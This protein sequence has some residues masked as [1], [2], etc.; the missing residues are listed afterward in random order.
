MRAS[1]GLYPALGRFF[2]TKKEL[3]D[4]GCMSRQRLD[5][6]LNGLKDFT[7][8]EKRALVANIMA[9]MYVNEIPQDKEI[10]LI[11]LYLAYNGQFDTL[12]RVKE[13][14]SA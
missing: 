11:D 2:E 1:C 7:D 5:E 8:Q 12:F 6:C 9:R 14:I 3:A 4:A 10:G 13:R